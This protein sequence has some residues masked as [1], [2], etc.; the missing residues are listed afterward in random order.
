MTD[1]SGS[2]LPAAVARRTEI[3]E[4]LFAG[5]LPYDPQPADEATSLCSLARATHRSGNFAPHAKRHV[6][7][8]AGLVDRVLADHESLA[9]SAQ[10]NP[11]TIFCF[12]GPQQ[13]R[14]VTE[15]VTH[16]C[17]QW[18]K[19]Q[20]RRGLPF[21]FSAPSAPSRWLIIE[22]AAAVAVAATPRNG[23]DRVNS[24]HER[25]R[26]AKLLA[27]WGPEFV[28]QW[29]DGTI[30]CRWAQVQEMP[31][32]VYE[33][34]R[35]AFG[36]AELRAV[37]NRHPLDPLGA[38]GGVKARFEGPLSAASIVEKVGWS[39]DAVA[40]I[41]TPS[42]RLVL[43]MNHSTGFDTALQ[44]IKHSLEHVVT[45]QNLAER[46]GLS[47][48]RVREIFAPSRR[49]AFAVTYTAN[50]LAACDVWYR[51]HGQREGYKSNANLVDRDQEQLLD[52]LAKS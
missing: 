49:I 21:I 32:E 40:L 28:A 51:S 15:V 44:R 16:M 25:K 22:A 47:D 23:F 7:S 17:Q 13:Q 33:T 10:E 19:T 27:I 11:E 18:E 3:Y 29:F 2:V 4:V 8:L 14:F 24:L 12:A 30:L 48:H 42:R 1:A 6:A 37:A 9:Q 26:L 46:Y 20:A 38:L 45:C 34:W 43:A 36:P 41:F 50:P 31:D 39:T 35:L 5:E 52:D